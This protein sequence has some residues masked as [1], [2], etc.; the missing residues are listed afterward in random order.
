VHKL[1]IAVDKLARAQANV[2][3]DIR[4]PARRQRRCA[5]SEAVEGQRVAESSM[6]ACARLTAL[7]AGAR[8]RSERSDVA[9][10]P[11]VASI[12]EKLRS[13]RSR[14]ENLDQAIQ[15]KPAQRHRF[16]APNGEQDD[17][18]PRPPISP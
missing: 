10:F 3:V 16:G 5:S 8:C 1:A 15:A 14:G 7:A 9:R 17:A 12:I 18:R 11:G 13:R 4:E 6:A 2:T